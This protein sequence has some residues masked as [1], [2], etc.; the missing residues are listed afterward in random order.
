M[1]EHIYNLEQM[2]QEDLQFGAAYPIARSQTL[3]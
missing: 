1:S 2:S 3:S